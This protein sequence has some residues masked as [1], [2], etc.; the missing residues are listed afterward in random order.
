[1]LTFHSIPV[2]TPSDKKWRILKK[3][4]AESGKNKNTRTRG[5]TRWTGTIDEGREP[6]FRIVQ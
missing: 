2:Q 4:I 1:M 3:V 5:E 6:F